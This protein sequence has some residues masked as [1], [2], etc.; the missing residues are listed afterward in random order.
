MVMG[1]D[2]WAHVKSSSELV[3][4]VLDLGSKQ[5]IMLQLALSKKAEFDGLHCLRHAWV[6][7]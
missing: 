7:A 1:A 5:M 4:A 3:T 2:G 6:M